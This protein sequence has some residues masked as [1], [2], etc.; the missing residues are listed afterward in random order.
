[1]KNE[2]R[3]KIEWKTCLRVGISIFVLFLCIHY[4]TSTASV[5]K[6]FIG[7]VLPLIIGA[8]VAYPLSI[9]MNFYGRLYPHTLELRST[10][11][12]QNHG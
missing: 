5:I 11:Q 4:W 7:A 3:I 12:E 2:L 10:H 9:L 6:T 8:V 1:M